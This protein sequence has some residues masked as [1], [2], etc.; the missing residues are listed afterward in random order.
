VKVRR[1]WQLKTKILFRDWSIEM[2][3]INECHS[4]SS[5]FIKAS[6]NAIAKGKIWSE[7]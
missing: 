5:F 2:S 3:F 4:W 7:N 1:M 6:P